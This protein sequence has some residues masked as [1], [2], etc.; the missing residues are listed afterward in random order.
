MAPRKKKASRPATQLPGSVDTL[1]HAR[2]GH[3][4]G[5]DEQPTRDKAKATRRE[6]ALIYGCPIVDTGWRE[7]PLSRRRKPARLPREEQHRSSR[8]TRGVVARADRGR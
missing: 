4:G 2:T 3:D 1:R 8:N 6:E 5:G 7:K